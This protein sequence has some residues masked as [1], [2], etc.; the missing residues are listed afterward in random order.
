MAYLDEQT[1]RINEMYNNLKKQKLGELTSQRDQST[2]DLRRTLSEQLPQYQT[3]RAQAD[4]GQAQNLNRLKEYMAS[5]G[6]FNSGD[7][8]TRASN[9]LTARA[10][11]VN[12]INGNENA[13]TLGINNR[14]ADAN[15]QFNTNVNSV[16]AGLDAERIKAIEDLRERL[17]QEQLQRE[18]EDRQYQR[19][20]ALAAK[21]RSSGSS[22]S[23]PSVSEQNAAAKANAQAI[24]GNVMTYLDQW[25]SGQA[26]DQSGRADRS[27]MLNYIKA[28]SGILTQQGVDTNSLT[29]WVKNNYTWD[30]DSSGSWYNTAE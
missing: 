25:A 30:R 2:T 27:S 17:R 21:S 23:K 11:A 4:V 22:S 10:N 9:V 26:S 24:T 28:N 20:L 5:T 6:A 13:F 29:N 15:N 18:A 1:N 7:N 14:I 16:N 3:A 12:Q 8:F 19:Q